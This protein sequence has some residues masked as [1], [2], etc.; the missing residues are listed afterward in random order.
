[1]TLEDMP[2]MSSRAHIEEVHKHFRALATLAICKTPGLN[3]KNLQEFPLLCGEAV[4]TFVKTAFVHLIE[5][6]ACTTARTAPGMGFADSFQEMY[7]AAHPLVCNDRD[8]N[9][10]ADSSVQVEDD[11]SEDDIFT[12]RFNSRGRRQNT[13]SSDSSSDSSSSESDS[14]SGS[15][16]DGDNGN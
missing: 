2:L 5:Q 8:A 16:D 4:E 7:L 13:T 11:D 3:R 15:D 6:Q 14:G 12:Q 9:S 1:M 10:A